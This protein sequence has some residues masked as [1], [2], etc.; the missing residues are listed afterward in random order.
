MWMSRKV[1]MRGPV[2][3]APSRLPNRKPVSSLAD[4]LDG[5]E[6]TASLRVTE[7]HALVMLKLLALDDRYRNIRSPAEARHDREESRTHAADILAIVSAQTNPAQFKEA[8]QRQFEAD[9]PLGMRVSQVLHEY[10]SES[11]S[12]GLLVYEGF[13][14]ADRP[15]HRDARRD[16]AQLVEQLLPAERAKR[17]TRKPN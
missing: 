10:F 1:L 15:L 4:C 5:L 2:P 9:P 11:T 14:V 13:L 6:F 8:F 3:A 12:P 17:R 7:P 16:V